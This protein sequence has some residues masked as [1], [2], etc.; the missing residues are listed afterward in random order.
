MEIEK[1]IFEIIDKWFKSSKRLD[2]SKVDGTLWCNIND[3]DIKELK[4]MIQDRIIKNLKL[5]NKK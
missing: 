4:Q 3:Y 2:K 5:I 1:Q